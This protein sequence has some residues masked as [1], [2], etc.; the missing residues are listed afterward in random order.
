MEGLRGKRAYRT[1]GIPSMLL[2]PKRKLALV[3]V[4]FAK[5]TTRHGG[6]VLSWR[7][8]R[9]SVIHYGPRLR[10]CSRRRCESAKVGRSTQ[11]NTKMI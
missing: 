1:A 4:L 10:L 6:P 8:G 5:A 11:Q 7:T 2:L 9:R 3:S